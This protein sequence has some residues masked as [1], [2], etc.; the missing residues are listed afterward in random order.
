MKGVQ[1]L[2]KPP[3]PPPQTGLRMKKVK[4][5]FIPERKKTWSDTSSILLSFYWE[6]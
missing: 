1:A 6:W 2:L 4:N 3:P 5:C